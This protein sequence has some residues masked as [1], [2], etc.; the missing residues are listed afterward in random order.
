M[1]LHKACNK[2]NLKP[3]YGCEFY[4]VEDVVAMRENQQRDKYHLTVMAMNDVGYRNLLQLVSR[5]YKEGFYYRPTIDKQML[6]EHNSGLVVSVWLLFWY[7]TN[8]SNE[9]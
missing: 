5:S 8:P 2:S 4:T 3:I 6:F 9:W 7:V 1:Q